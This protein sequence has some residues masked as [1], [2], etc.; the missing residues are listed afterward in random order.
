[1]LNQDV[2]RRLSIVATE[3]GLTS[4]NTKLR[5]HER[6]QAQV[7]AGAARMS[8]AT[9]AADRRMQALLRQRDRYV[10]S[11]NAGGLGGAG[12]TAGADL[13]A[14]TMRNVAPVVAAV[15]AVAA[16][17]VAL[18]K[19]W[20]TGA[21]LLEKYGKAYRQF[22]RSD[23]ASNMSDL[24]KYQQDTISASQVQRASELGVRLEEAKFT[25]DQ[26]FKVHLNIV[27]P[28]L[29]L[30][31]AWVRIVEA[32]AAGTAKLGTMFEMRPPEWLTKVIGWGLGSSP[33]GLIVRGFNALAGPDGKDVSQVEALAAAYKNLGAAMGTANIGKDGGPLGG[34]FAARWGD[35]IKQLDEVGKKTKEVAKATT[36][37]TT[38]F[39]RAVASASK[40]IAVQEAEARAVGLGAGAQ[41]K[42]R[43]EAELTESAL[44]SK[45]DPA[46]EEVAK[47]IEAIGDRAAKAATELARARLGDQIQFDRETMFFTDTERQIAQEMKNLY[48]ADW[49]KN[50]DSVEAKQLRINAAMKDMKDVTVD[51]AQTF[52]QGMMDGKSATEALN[53]AL[54]NLGQKMMN[55]GIGNAI[56][57]AFSGNPTQ[58]AGGLLQAGIGW[59]LQQFQRREM[60]QR[61]AE[62]AEI[63]RQEEIAARNRAKKQMIEQYTL[64]G[65]LAGLDQSTQAGALEAFD[66]RAASELRQAARTPGIGR[67]EL[68]VAEEALAKERLKIIEDFAKQAL[69]LER[70]YE[71]RIFA[72]TTDASTEAGALAAFDRAAMRERE[73]AVEGGSIAIGKLEEALSAERIK[74]VED[75]AKR[76]VD[77][78]RSYEDR[79]FAATND[80]TTLEGQLAAFDRA[81]NREREEAIKSGGIAI[82]SLERALAAERLQ[83]IEQ[84]VGD[85]SD[86]TSR[87]LSYQDRL[88]AATND[89]ST[90]EGALAAF[91]RQAQREREE[92]IAAGGEAIL[93]LEAALNAERLQVI[94]SFNSKIVDDTRSAEEQRRQ[95]LI[96]T[97]QQVLQ[98]IQQLQ[99]GAESP[100]SPGA[101]LAAAQTSYDSTRTLAM[102]GNAEAY[103]QFTQVAESLRQAA[104]DMYGSAAGYQTIFNNIVADGLNLTSPVAASDPVVAKLQ[105]V[106]TA[107][108]VANGSIVSTSNGNVAAINAV[109]SAVNFHKASDEQQFFAVRSRLED[110]RSSV[111]TTRNTL[112]GNILGTTAAVGNNATTISGAIGNT[113]TAVNTNNNLVT[114]GNTIANNQID[115]AEDQVTLLQA[116]ENLGDIQR[117]IA[118]E[119]GDLMS[120][121]GTDHSYW[122]AEIRKFTRRTADGVGAGGGSS[123][124]GGNFWDWIG[125]EKGGVVGNGT[126]GRDSV[127][128]RY[129]G[130]GNI[131]L[132]GGE[133]V[134]TAGATAAIGGRAAIDYINRTGMMPANDNGGVVAAIENMNRNLSAMLARIAS[135]EEKNASLTA[136][137]L[138]Q[139]S[140]WKDNDDRKSRKVAA[141]AGR[142]A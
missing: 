37:A 59:G 108:G 125:F 32:V 104:K 74:I 107:I 123:D 21:D 14:F 103:A 79:I 20:E 58:A 87:L 122:L 83:I 24:T 9:E 70:S 105:E 17:Y 126:Y 44:R 116:I 1:M 86:A 41:A 42:F 81:A 133:G 137:L 124:P 112:S 142:A 94:Q 98:Y 43:A 56:S 111:D 16:A 60:E 110:T 134:L 139:N 4:V 80:T 101:R 75:F 51:F 88:F 90:L 120:E 140:E 49:Q 72:A 114:A 39:D 121:I 76:A 141:K 96:Q 25:I 95:A 28:A 55:E 7:T 48:G 128:A 18:N 109:T 52:V 85:V 89:A 27:D 64:R 33:A 61:A 132:A 118:N 138:Q 69:E 100:L 91:D 54:A 119:Q 63:A 15:G 65:S 47:K 57:G 3:T 34:S 6:L 22:D 46:A 23:L 106:V 66:L 5:E 113:T 77:I 92:E 40:R 62:Q 71:D 31:A 10:T 53:A 35:T 38:A 82:E 73:L 8:T 50:M 99:T 13:G 136:Q 115:V 30:Q 36:E 135:L 68:V 67:H 26:F 19:V 78:E 102:Q 29:K 12:R 2:V 129:A 131:M 127:M 11:F 93:D 117:S 84:F 97:T 130:G 45:L